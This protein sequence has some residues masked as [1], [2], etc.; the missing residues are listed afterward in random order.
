VYDATVTTPVRRPIAALAL[1]AILFLSSGGIAWSQLSASPGNPAENDSSRARVVN[2]STEMVSIIV[3][4][5]STIDSIVNVPPMTASRPIP[6]TFG[7]MLL[8]TR[9][10]SSEWSPPAS[11]LVKS[12]MIYTVLFHSGSAGS[13]STALYERGTSRLSDSLQASPTPRVDQGQ[14]RLTLLSRSTATFRGEI[15]GD[16]Q[17]PGGL[18][19]FGREGV[20]Q[21]SPIVNVDAGAIHIDLYGVTGFPMLDRIRLQGVNAGNRHRIIL[22][23]R[24]DST[25]GVWRYDELAATSQSLVAVGHVSIDTIQGKVRLVNLFF[26]TR[27]VGRIAPATDTL[28]VAYQ[29]TSRWIGSAGGRLVLNEHSSGDERHN[30]TFGLARRGLTSLVIYDNLVNESPAVLALHTVPRLGPGNLPALRVAN[31]TGETF[32]GSFEVKREG[33]RVARFDSMAVDMV[34]PYQRLETRNIPREFS[35]YSSEN[36]TVPIAELTLRPGSYTTLIVSTGPILSGAQPVDGSRQPGA[37]GQFWIWALHEFPDDSTTSAL[38]LLSY[39]SS[40]REES[41][42]ERARI[43][44]NPSRGTLS[45]H[46][47]PKA[48]LAGTLIATDMLGRIVADFG[49]QRL[50]A[51]GTTIEVDLGG[52]ASGVYTLSIIEK[53]GRRVFVGGVTRQ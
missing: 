23:S 17:K 4:N 31:A 28:N 47:E 29:S 49:E 18:F 7:S 19:T 20:G 32:R 46:L 35:L 24:P 37:V 33:G 15:L 48:P 50:A 30:D 44:P 34:L 10:G 36:A 3:E 26:S 1:M 40:V 6:L 38:T 45:I 16:L 13:I 8:R 5:G 53:G 9:A 51:G 14:I 12:R 25:F 22:E 21:E 11:S 39:P 2:M 52:L 27:F 41:L 42:V 43:W